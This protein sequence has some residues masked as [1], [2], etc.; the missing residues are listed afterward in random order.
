VIELLFRLEKCCSGR[1]RCLFRRLDA[2]LDKEEATE[3]L[4]AVFPSVF[5]RKFCF[6]WIVVFAEERLRVKVWLHVETWIRTLDAAPDQSAIPR[7]GCGS[8]WKLGF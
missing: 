5:I 2:V 6:P 8:V 7:L 4:Q 3:A 1:R